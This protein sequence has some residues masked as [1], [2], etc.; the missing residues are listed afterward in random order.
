MD[1]MNCNACTHLVEVN[2]TGIC[3]GCQMGFA[4]PQSDSWKNHKQE[5][6]ILNK[7]LEDKYAFKEGIEQEDSGSEHKDGNSSGEGPQAGTSDRPKRRRQAQK[8]NVQAK[9]V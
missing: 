8:K 5:P 3:L 4:G 6:S 9:E 2:P 1:Y 7:T